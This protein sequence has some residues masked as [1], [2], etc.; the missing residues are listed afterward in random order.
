MFLLRPYVEKLVNHFGKLAQQILRKCIKRCLP[1]LL[2][3]F[4]ALKISFWCKNS[5]S[6]VKFCRIGSSSKTVDGTLIWIE[7]ENIL[8]WSFGDLKKYNHFTRSLIGLK[9]GY[10]FFFLTFQEVIPRSTLKETSCPSFNSLKEWNFTLFWVV[11][12]LCG[13]V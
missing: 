12:A 13:V 2:G 11:F 7:L 10:I 9:K 4:S 8:P 5:P 6:F 3:Q 1:R